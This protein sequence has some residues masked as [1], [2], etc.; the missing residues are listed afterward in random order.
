MQLINAITDII[1]QIKMKNGDIKTSTYI[2]RDVKSND[3]DP[4]FNGL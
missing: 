3:K 4:K 2:Y 1:E